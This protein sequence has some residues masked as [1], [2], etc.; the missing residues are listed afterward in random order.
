MI[1]DIQ[2]DGEAAKQYWSDFRVVYFIVPVSAL[3]FV[4]LAIWFATLPYLFYFTEKEAG[5]DASKKAFISGLS[6]FFFLCCFYMCVGFYQL[7]FI[8][9]RE[10]F[11]ARKVVYKDGVFTLRGWYFKRDSFKEADYR[12]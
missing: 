2:S 11:I 4:G 6:I 3:V 5:G 10:K 7:F 8:E 9:L 12:V 1:G